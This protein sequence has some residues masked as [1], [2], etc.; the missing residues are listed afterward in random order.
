MVHYLLLLDQLSADVNYYLYQ[1]WI[2]IQDPRTKHF[3]MI[4]INPLFVI[5][6]LSFYYLLVNYLIP[7]YMENREPFQ[8]RELIL[9]YNTGMALG[10]LWAFILALMYIDFKEFFNF[11]YPTDKALTPTLRKEFMLGN[12]YK[13]D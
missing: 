3:P 10:N 2:D 5:I 11:V 8:L 13:H 1:Y 4:D 7:Y 9:T 12:I 6:L